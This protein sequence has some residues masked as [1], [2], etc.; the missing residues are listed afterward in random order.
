MIAIAADGN[1]HIFFL[2]FAIVDEE[3]TNTWGWFLVCL[4]TFVTSR[5]KICLIFDQYAGI[6]SVM[7][8]KY[9]DWQ[10]PYACH[11]YCLRHVA[12]NF[13]T[14]FRDSRL[15]DL[16]KRIGMVWLEK[17][18]DRLALDADVIVI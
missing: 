1:N 15:R 14:R 7:Q 18:F 10:P 13:N 4:R 6:L 5:Q 9:L 8:N 12:S 2:A 17:H 16:V 11:V 3:S